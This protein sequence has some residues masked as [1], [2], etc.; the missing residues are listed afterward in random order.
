MR[1]NPCACC[2]CFILTGKRVPMI[3]V[4]KGYAVCEAH[5]ELASTPTF[6]VFRLRT[7]PPMKGRAT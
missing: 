1:T 3:T 4:V 5:V 2:V 6:D 7:D